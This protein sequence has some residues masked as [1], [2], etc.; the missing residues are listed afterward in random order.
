MPTES[1]NITLNQSEPIN[2]TSTP[3]ESTDQTST[4]TE[5]INTTLNQSEPI[6]STSPPTELTEPNVSDISKSSG[7]N[8]FNL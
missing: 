8:F 6:D 2:S 3:T 5:S 1:I 7:T 4:P